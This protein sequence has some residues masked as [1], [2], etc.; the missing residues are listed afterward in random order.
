MKSKRRTVQI[1]G[2][3]ELELLLPGMNHISFNAKKFLTAEG[4]LVLTVLVDLCACDHNE[5][6]CGNF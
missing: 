2:D 4:H 5:L 3:I 1:E 6:L